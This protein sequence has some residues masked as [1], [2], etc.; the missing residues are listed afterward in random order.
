MT[1]SEF[2]KKVASNAGITQKLVKQVLDASEISLK[3]MLSDFDEDKRVKVM[4]VTYSVKTRAEHNGRN[5]KTGEAIVIPEHKY[6]NTKTSSN[7]KELF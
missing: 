4:D 5:P 1:N 2:V 3:E 6:V 7:F